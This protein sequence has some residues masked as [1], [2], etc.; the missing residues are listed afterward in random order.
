[1]RMDKYHEEERRRD[2][3]K[4]K[5]TAI[6]VAAAL[7]ITPAA[8]VYKVEQDKMETMQSYYEAL[9]QEST[10][11]AYYE[12]FLDALFGL[13]NEYYMYND[14]KDEGIVNNDISSKKLTYTKKNIKY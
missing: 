2:E 9:I 7:A 14:P 6:V 5:I 13:N 10:Q 4:D 1:M 3:L 11:K 12:G 8:V